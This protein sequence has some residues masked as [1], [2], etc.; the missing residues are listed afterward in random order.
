MQ[1]P[2]GVEVQTIERGSRLDHRVEQHPLGVAKVGQLGV[3][4]RAGA[5]EQPHVAFFAQTHEG[6][7]VLARVGL[8]PVEHAGRRLVD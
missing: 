3:D 5:H 2:R 6:F 8:T 7:D 4:Q 1:A